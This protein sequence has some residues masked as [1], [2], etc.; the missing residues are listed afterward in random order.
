M[1]FTTTSNLLLVG[2]FGLL[3]LTTATFAQTTNLAAARG[4]TNP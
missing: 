3:A 1:R 2:G 4:N